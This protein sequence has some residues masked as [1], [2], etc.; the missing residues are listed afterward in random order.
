MDAMRA[1]GTSKLCMNGRDDFHVVPNSRLE[2]WDDVEVVRTRFM[3]AMGVG[4]MSG[5]QTNFLI[6]SGP[7]VTHVTV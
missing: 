5:S 6:S 3:V 2:K 1:L 4:W 7:H